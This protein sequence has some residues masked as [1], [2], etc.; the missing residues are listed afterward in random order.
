MGTRAHGTLSVV[1]AVTAPPRS[2]GGPGDHPCKD[3]TLWGRWKKSHLGRM[4]GP[5]C[6]PTPSTA[7]E[8]VR[9]QGPHRGTE[10]MATLSEQDPGNILSSPVKMSHAAHLGSSTHGGHKDPVQQAGGAGEQHSWQP[11]GPPLQPVG[12]AGEQHPWRPRGPP[13]QPAGGAGEQ[14]PGGHEDPHCSRLE[15]MTS[16]WCG[17]YGEESTQ[18]R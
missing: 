8:A 15:A 2:P 3:E 5:T 1:S 18:Q 10:V 12:G 11:R 6:S 14:H 17:G 13:L 9:G 4:L 7:A 16:G